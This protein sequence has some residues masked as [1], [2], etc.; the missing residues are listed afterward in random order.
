MKQKIIDK[1]LNTTIHTSILKD[2]S[3]LLKIYLNCKDVKINMKYGKMK[4]MTLLHIAIKC[5]HIKCIYMLLNNGA[6][7]N[8]KDAEGMSS[9]DYAKFL[10]L[11]YIFTECDK[12][13]FKN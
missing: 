2:R 1:I 8:L 5:C 9:I 13:R 11:D 3:D 4:D 10:K 7:M 12:V 6:D